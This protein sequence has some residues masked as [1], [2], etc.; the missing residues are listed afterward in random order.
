M[1]TRQIPMMESEQGRMS[2]G[3]P[4]PFTELM[5]SFPLGL[6]NVFNEAMIKAQDYM[7]AV[8]V[9]TSRSVKRFGFVADAFA[10]Q[11]NDVF[12]RM[13]GTNIIVQLEAPLIDHSGAGIC[14]HVFG[15]SKKFDA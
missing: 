13:T 5:I 10:Y 1:I 7:F 8:D 12:Y 9:I 3:A 6:E 2:N 15:R 4:R 14:M 11:V